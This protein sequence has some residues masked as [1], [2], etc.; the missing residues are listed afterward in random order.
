MKSL[1]AVIGSLAAMT[2]GLHAQ[3]NVNFASLWSFDGT[4]GEDP[5]SGL[6]QATDGNFYGTTASDNTTNGTIF[7]MTPSG[8]FRSLIIFNGTNG[9]NPRGTLI[10]GHDGYLY[11]TAYAKGTNG[12]GTL[13]QATTNGSLTNLY[14]FS[15]LGG[16]YPIGSLVQDQAGDLFGTTS[17]GG[18]NAGGTVF[19]LT[20]GGV[21]QTLVSFGLSGSGGDSPY[22]GLVQS[23]DG[24][25]YGT[26]SSGGTNDDG[27]VF[28][29]QMDGTQATLISF[30]QT[31]GA[32]P[33]SGLVF[34]PDGQLYGTTLNGGLY[35]YG[36]VFKLSTNGLL[37]TLVSFN[38][39][40]G[41]NPQAGL[42]FGADGNLYG[43][44][45]AGGDLSVQPNGH[46]TVFETDTNGNL[47]T[48]V[49]FNGT[50]GDSPQG[51]LIQAQDGT[52]YGTTAN[53]GTNG[54]GTIFRFSL[55][56]SALPQFLSIVSAGQTVTFSWSAN[57]QK[58]YQI[59]YKTNLN[60]PAW[61]NLNGSVMATNPIMTTVDTITS[62]PQRFYQ[63]LM[64][65]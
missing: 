31:N 35:G 57:M 49:L 17:L 27:T 23:P 14:S 47:S 45:T 63:I 1:L 6:V 56:P 12:F 9:A 58:S 40:N 61:G 52:F 18:T 4:N 48:L 65:P 36:T 2:S 26:T 24:S 50:N 59:L 16:G 8:G 44:T 11:G 51:N 28:R 7:Q 3:T 30:N 25:Y 62:D 5:Q 20:T 21:F 32:S 39:T 22:A 10:L 60:Q 42:I 54:V 38:N 29:V 53:G 34:G 15:F 64:L 55:I 46:G 33:Y 43:T 37:R 41:A 19:E 13:F